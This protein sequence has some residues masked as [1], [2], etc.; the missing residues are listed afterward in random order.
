MDLHTRLGV[1]TVRGAV[2]GEV[3]GAVQGAVRVGVDGGICGRTRRN[4]K[5][6]LSAEA[7]H[8]RDVRE[9]R[10]TAGERDRLRRPGNAIQLS[11]SRYRNGGG[12]WY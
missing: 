10:G 6:E 3:Q 7:R 9:G 4:G 8:S 5:R 11:K 12:D 1:T 2:Q